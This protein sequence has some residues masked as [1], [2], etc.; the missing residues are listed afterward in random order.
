[1]NPTLTHLIAHARQ[2]ELR[3]SAR[4]RAVIPTQPIRAARRSHPPL[5]RV[6]GPGPGASRLLRVT[7]HFIEPKEH[8]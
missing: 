7:H 2:D 3:R 8:P 4:C 1:M 6:S 5:H